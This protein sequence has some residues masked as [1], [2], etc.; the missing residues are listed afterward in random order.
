MNSRTYQA[1]PRRSRESILKSI[2][3]NDPKEIHEAL[4]SAAY[5]DEDWQWVQ[6]LLL[7]FAQHES[8][9]VLSAVVLGFCF[10]AVFHGEGSEPVVAAALT[11]IKERCPRLRSEVE[12]TEADIEHF[13]RKRRE[14][15]QPPFGR[16]LPPESRPLGTIPRVQ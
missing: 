3:S 5:W 8:E 2:E 12:N 4:D 15:G 14:G 7:R 10:L 16:R 11:G 13:V 6:T 1:I 9:T